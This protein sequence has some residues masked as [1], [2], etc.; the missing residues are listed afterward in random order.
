MKKLL[1]I[2]SLVLFS[3]SAQAQIIGLRC[4]NASF[5]IINDEDTLMWL[6]IDRRNKM[7]SVQRSLRN[8]SWENKKIISLTDN[9]I[10]AKGLSIDRYSGFAKLNGNLYKCKKSNRV[11]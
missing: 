5:D 9:E 1:L 3:F 8:L 4:E 7:V 10:V 2:L 11:F 6:K